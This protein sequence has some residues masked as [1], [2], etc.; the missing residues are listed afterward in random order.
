M[1][2]REWDKTTRRMPHVKKDGDDPVEN[3]DC[4]PNVGCSPRRSG[5]RRAHVRDLTPIEGE[6]AHG[7]AVGDAGQLV[8]LGIVGDYPTNPG[9]I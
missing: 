2:M 9:E 7:H 3:H 5:K 8:N 6:N 1:R 4:K